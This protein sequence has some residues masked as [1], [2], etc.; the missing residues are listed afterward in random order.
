VSSI[1]VEDRVT[2][3]IGSATKLNTIGLTPYYDSIAA[4]ALNPADEVYAGNYYATVEKEWVLEK[5]TDFFIGA[6]RAGY[7]GNHSQLEAQQALL[8]ADLNITSAAQNGRIHVIS[9]DIQT[10]PACIIAMA[11]M[12]KWFYPDLFTDLDP[13]ELHQE[14]VDMFL[15]GAVDVSELNSFAL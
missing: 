11:Y 13:E 1:A 7:N 4:G 5:N 14:Y 10:G 9:Y 3:L 2:V 15:N 6:V 8:A 12:A